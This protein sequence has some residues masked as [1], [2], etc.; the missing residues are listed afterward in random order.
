MSLFLNLVQAS[1]GVEG[2]QKL[3]WRK[4]CTQLWV[5]NFVR[6]VRGG[7]CQGKGGKH[8]QFH[9]FN[10]NPELSYKCSQSL[11]KLAFKIIFNCFLCHPLQEGG[12]VAVEY[13]IP[14]ANQAVLKWIKAFWR[15]LQISRACWLRGGRKGFV[16]QTFLQVPSCCCAQRGGRQSAALSGIRWTLL[17]KTSLGC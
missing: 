13:I 7:I 6:L 11:A 10:L 9:W 14:L 4:N 16:A 12:V 3:F 2:E 15:K 1:L 17:R 8:F 5:E